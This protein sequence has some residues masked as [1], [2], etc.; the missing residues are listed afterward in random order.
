MISADAGVG[1]LAE[2]ETLVAT[3]RHDG[4]RRHGDRHLQRTDL[5]DV[6]IGEV[7]DTL[8]YLELEHAKWRRRNPTILVTLVA[9]HLPVSGCKTVALGEAIEQL[10]RQLEVRTRTFNQAFGERWRYGADRFGDQYLRRDNLAEA[11]EEIADVEIF[12]GL[13]ADRRR[14]QGIAGAPE[15]ALL[16]KT[17]RRLAISVLDLSDRAAGRPLR[18]AA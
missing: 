12:L 17:A 1:S 7:A 9:D 10:A 16:I 4:L 8:V 11:L 18:Q 2:Y 6:A 15:C 13:E 5:L 3:R 14:F